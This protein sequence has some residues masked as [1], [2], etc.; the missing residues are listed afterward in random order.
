MASA[1]ARPGACE[2]LGTPEAG[3]ADFVA[4][5]LKVLAEIHPLISF[6]RQDALFRIA[7]NCVICQSQIRVEALELTDIVSFW[8]VVLR[9]GG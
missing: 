6:W 5:S 9:K 1:D 3:A 2:V 7:E 8:L 4:A